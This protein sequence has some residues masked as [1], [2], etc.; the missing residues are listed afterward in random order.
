MI[1]II[2]DKVHAFAVDPNA[3]GYILALVYS[4]AAIIL[5]MKPHGP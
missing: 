4:I 5:L 3:P 2:R 1:K